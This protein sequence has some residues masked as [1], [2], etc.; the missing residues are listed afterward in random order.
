[1]STAF[2]P[3]EK[4]LFQGDRL[5]AFQRDDV[6]TPP[7]LIEISPT[8]HCNAK[9]PWCFYVSSDYKQRHSREEIDR[10]VL[11]RTLEDLAAT[12]VP[13]ITW[14]GGGDPS[15]YSAIDDM[16]D[17]AHS[18]G[19][20]QGM[21]TNA[22]KR[23][24]SPEKL[25]WI[26]VTVTEI[27]TLTR[28][29]WVYAQATKTGVNF[30]LCEANQHELREMLDQARL[31]GVAYFQIRPA[32]ADRAELQ[33]PVELPTWAM[34]Y[35]TD[36]MRV[37]LTPYKFEDHASPHGYPICHGH[38]FVPF[39]WH[40]GDLAVCAYHFGQPDYTFGNLNAE[41]FREIWL[42]ERRRGMLAKGVDVI[43]ACQHCCKNHEV[44]KV[45]ASLR[46]EYER[47]EDVAFL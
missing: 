15:V 21:F 23:L 36:T 32:L 22:Y 26:R 20:K 3:K 6:S 24:R 16:I 17:L 12:G 31:R 2:A 40:N 7:A 43:P 33:Q 19:L 29:V 44:N 37:V 41:T 14:T 1:M 28:N 34:D 25:A 13:A 47:P 4:L 18:L 9:C 39:I 42:G 45:L 38:R 11:A 46:G 8:N 27:F 30:N 5:A 10:D 35:Q